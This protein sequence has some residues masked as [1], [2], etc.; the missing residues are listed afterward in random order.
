MRISTDPP[1][2]LTYCLNV[3]PGETWADNLAAIR[4]HALRV[5]TRVAPC[6]PFGLGLRLSAKAAKELASPTAMSEFRKFL[7][8]ENLYVFTIN[9]FPYGQFHDAAV[10]QNVYS[11]D[12]RTARRRDY[13]I[14]MSNVLAELLPEG[15]TGSIS[16]VPCSYKPWI[17]GARDVRQMVEMLCDAVAHLAEIHRRRGREI[18]LAPEPEPD[19][20]I[21]TTA[22]AIAFFSGPLV[23]FGAGYL[24]DKLAT[25]SSAAE[26]L[27]HR[28]LGLCFDTSHLAVE[29][30]D[31]TAA[32]NSLAA[33]GIRIAKVHLSAALQAAPSPAA[34]RQL[35]AFCD[36]VYLHQVK[37]RSPDGRITSCADLP[38][39]L[40]AADA[41][42]ADPADQWRIH[43]HVPLFFERLGELSSTSWLLTRD[44]AAALR[45]GATEHLE[46]ETYTFSVLPDEIRPADIA[47]GIA[48]EYEWVFQRLLRR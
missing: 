22:E 9:G 29:F 23:E 20:S 25:T 14:D 39:A 31:L 11:P 32:V 19:C 17:A 12:W 47:D 30:E 44:F 28:H 33:A 1:L 35:K 6:E 48:R 43:F 41:K 18:V 4:N 36:P 3:H 45:R 38:A 8:G 46:I 27:I 37:V 15:V 5:R 40:A 2:H 42:D 10:K 24:A 16:T 13:T 21:E 7:A 34:R 26:Q